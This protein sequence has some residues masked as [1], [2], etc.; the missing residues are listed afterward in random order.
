MTFQA[1]SAAVAGGAGT[2]L[3]AEH[4]V[5]F[6]TVLLT[7]LADVFGTAGTEIAVAALLPLLAFEAGAIAFRAY[8]LAVAVVA[9]PAGETGFVVALGA[10]LFAVRTD[11]GTVIASAASVAVQTISV[12]F[13]AV[14]AEMELV[15]AIDAA[16]A[17]LARKPVVPVPFAA[18]GAFHS[19]LIV[20]IR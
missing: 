9:A 1:C 3:H 4:I 20:C 2:A 12:A 5:T 6:G 16:A 8:G 13:A 7:A 17:L 18:P 11:E 10:V 19:V 15:E 14:R